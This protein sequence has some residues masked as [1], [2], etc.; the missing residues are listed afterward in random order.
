MTKD[1][2]KVF[3]DYHIDYILRD[4]HQPYIF[5]EMHINEN[6]IKE[7]DLLIPVVIPET[8]TQTIECLVF[9]SNENKTYMYRGYLYINP[10]GENVKKMTLY[11]RNGKEVAFDPK[12]DD[13]SIFTEKVKMYVDN[14]DNFR[15]IDKL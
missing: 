4:K 14:Y 7:P 10:K 1:D 9:R 8:Y 3:Q 13:A 2:F 5:R 12:I 6:H 11:S 15:S